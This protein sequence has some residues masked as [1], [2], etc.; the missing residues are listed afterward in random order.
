MT[1]SDRSV[2]K[3]RKTS[4]LF[5][6]F[7]GARHILPPRTSLLLVRQRMIRSASGSYSYYN[8]AA[9]CSFTY[10]EARYIA[11]ISQIVG[12]LP[13][14]RGER[15]PPPRVSQ[16]Q[17]DKV[18]LTSEFQ[19]RAYC[20]SSA[21]RHTVL[22][23]VWDFAHGPQAPLIFPYIIVLLYVGTHLVGQP[24]CSFLAQARDHPDVRTQR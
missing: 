16:S 8:F 15:L 14:W 20:C 6:V 13:A 22:Q 23:W 5:S 2:P 11:R 19:I 10:S 9:A 1:V 17:Y 4:T 18:G 7:N 12:Q 3:S 21:E 24:S